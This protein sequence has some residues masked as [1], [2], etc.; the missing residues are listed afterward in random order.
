MAKEVR[1]TGIAASPGIAIGRAFVYRKQAPLVEKR[2][3]S[4]AGTEVARFRGGLDRARGELLE[5]KRQIADRLGESE[6][7][8]WDAQV[9]LLDDPAAIEATVERIRGQ[10]QDAASAF[11]ETMETMVRG[12]EATSNLYLRERAAD[13]RDLAWRVIKHLQFQTT[14]IPLAI[15]KQAVVISHDLSPADAAQLLSRKA[16]GFVTEVGGTT[17]HT[18]IVARSLEIPA[19]VGLKGAMLGAS[20]GDTVIVDGTRGAVVFNPGEKTT[21]AYRREL[22]G[23]ARHQQELQRL[24]KQRAVTADGHAVE[25]AANIELPEEMASVKSHGAHGVGLFRTEF[26]YLTSNHMPS[27]DEQELIYRRVAER[28]RP[29]P[30]IIRTFDLGGDKIGEDYQEANPF[31]GWRA[32][33]YCLDRPELF[34]TQLRAIL[35]ASA[36]GTV[37]IMLPMIS[38]PD[39]VRRSRELLES[40]RR[41]LAA[42]GTAFGRD[43]KLGI[44]VET[45]AAA[46]MAAELAPCCDFFSIG[47]NDLTQ[48]TLAVDRTNERVAKLYDPFHPAVLRLI[49]E[50]IDAGHRAGIWVGLC[51]EMGADPLAVPLLLGL[52]LDELSVSPAA[53]PEVKKI[54]VGLRFD[55]CR[56]LAA[57][58]MELTSSAEA[59]A[60][61][62]DFLCKTIPGV[63]L[64]DDTCPLEIE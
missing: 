9:L 22:K 40:C 19:V 50:V 12:M 33:R 42:A 11:Q 62:K 27:E 7:S 6:A 47:S 38:S 59:K 49:R 28:A 60:K 14:A 2:Q 24:R 43:V 16:A 31:L 45:P 54:V 18:A 44:M 36:H 55:Q 5:I 29:D 4:D 53:V 30:V 17:S 61:L 37:R 48:Y 3:V 26:I 1:L 63:Q 23:Y 56:A 46:L 21:S 39:E 64:I 34:K 10:R 13:V 25:L 20:Q 58:V 52:G 8:L 32:V 51:G 15:P 41:E 57:S 35:R